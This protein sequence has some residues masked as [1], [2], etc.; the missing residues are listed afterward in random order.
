MKEDSACVNSIFQKHK[1]PGIAVSHTLS[2]MDILIL[3]HAGS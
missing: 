3:K 2:G 1:C